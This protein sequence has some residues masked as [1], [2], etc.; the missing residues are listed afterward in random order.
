MLYPNPTSNQL[1]LD[2]N[3]TVAGNLTMQFI[4]SKG[5]LV[6]KKNVLVGIGR[7]V[8]NIDVSRFANAIYLI[9]YVEPDGKAGSVKFIKKQ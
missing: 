7:T 4:D 8:M 9:R 6:M 3:S 1:N 2:Y 5:A